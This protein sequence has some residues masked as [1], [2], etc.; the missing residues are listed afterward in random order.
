MC[1]SMKQNVV[2]VEDKSLFGFVDPCSKM[3]GVCLV[4]I[5]PGLTN[6]LL[7][8]FQQLLVDSLY[9]MVILN[10]SSRSNCQLTLM[11]VL[12]IYGK[13]LPLNQVPN[14]SDTM[15]NLVSISSINESDS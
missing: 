2:E 11:E 7:P 15:I 10:W 14:I 6:E 13:K 12:H 3:H 5:L 4:L 8:H 9:Y 1:L